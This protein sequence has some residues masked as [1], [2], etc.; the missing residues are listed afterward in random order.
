MPA[1]RRDQARLL[2]LD[3]RDG[4]LTH[5]HVQA[6]PDHLRRGDLLVVNDT[7]VIPAR[8]FART[9]AGAAVEL[10]LIRPTP[11]ETP[12]LSHLEGPPEDGG[13]SGR[14]EQILALESH[15][16]RA[17]EAPSSQGP[18]RSPVRELD[19][20]S[21]EGCW[22]C[23]GKPARRLRAGVEIR[24]PDG[25]RATVATVLGEGR[26][27]IA[28]DAAVDVHA[29]LERH[30][31]IPL[32]PYIRRPDGPLP[33]D[34]TRYQTVFA[35]T[36]GAI[37]APTAGLHFTDELLMLL[38]AGGVE[39]VRLTL[40]VGPGT[41]IPVRCADVREHVMEPEWCEISAEAAATI[42]RTKAAGGRIV[43]VGTTT[44]RA[45]ESAT[46]EDGIVQP[47][48]RWADRFIVPGHRFRVVDALFTNFHLPGSTLLLLV[49]AFAGRERVLS[50]YAEAVRC[51][52]RFYS[53]GDAMLVQ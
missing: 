24:F 3:R 42:R 15:T 49:S 48:A 4:S 33:V 16:V 51:R 1:E 22:L 32:P 34:H 11:F 46:S 21:K 12:V 5:T 14:T 47:G 7:R 38:R 43:A 37:A 50:T 26:Y 13:S 6:L 25:S 45:L 10:L 53:Y 29:L 44:T 18:S 23:L 20:A 8:I 28:F 19:D 36:P 9:A 40:H 30:G 41:F 17:E 39:T 35:S 27:C 31:E 2:V 52:Y